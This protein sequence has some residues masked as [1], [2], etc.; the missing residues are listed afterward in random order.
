[1]T[2]M[3]RS[4]VGRTR[5]GRATT[6]VAPMK[7]EGTSVGMGPRMR[8]DKGRESGRRWVPAYAR[9]REGRR[10]VR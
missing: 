9:T 10:W 7:R 2:V 8:E 6:R 4:P 3:Q 1:M 5:E